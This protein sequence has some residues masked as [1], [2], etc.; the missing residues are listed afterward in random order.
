MKVHT[1][2]IDSGERDP[3][4]YP[5]PGDYV[6]HL[7]NPIY[8]VSKI[9]LISA[10]IHNSQ[11]L[12]HNRN[13]TF[14]INGTTVSIPN[15]NYDGDDLMQA[16]VTASTHLSSGVY[17]K[18]TNAITFTGSAPFTFEFYGGTNGYASNVQGYTTPYDVLG[19]PASNVSSTT[20]SP[21]ELETG[22]I[23]LQGA[24]AIIVK[25]SSGSDEFNKTV[26]SETP[27]YTGRILLCGDVINYS[28]VDD[29][30]EHNFDSG[31]QKTISSLRVQFYYSSNNR[32]IPYDFR[33]A[34]HVLKLAITCSTDKLENVSKV[35]RDF[36]LPPPMSI[37][38]LEDPR[39]W[40]AFI[41]I[42][43]VV[44][45]G[46]FLLLVMRKPRLIE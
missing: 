21:Y 26:F 38:E 36:S 29:K 11:Y 10:R 40:D 6:V 15:G 32:L 16:V 19:L 17:D 44:A 18:D 12:I 8:D 37:P 28:G 43:M 1:L 30:I 9:S 41:S 35:E 46:L 23:N 13:N 39:R 3:N 20:L 27:F 2:D 5:N 22:S 42:F 34:N 33:N 4:V 14:D 31:T 24:D 25:L 45:T 7:K